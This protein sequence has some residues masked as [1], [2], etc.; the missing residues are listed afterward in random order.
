VRRVREAVLA[1][2]LPV[3]PPD[4]PFER[5]IELMSVDKKA[6]QGTPRFVLLDGPGS[7]RVARVPDALLRATIEA[8]AA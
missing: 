8:C 5:W 3:R 6:Q 1:A 2:R 7:A 4:W